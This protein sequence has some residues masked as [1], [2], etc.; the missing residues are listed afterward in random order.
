VKSCLKHTQKRRGDGKGG[1]EKRKEKRKLLFHPSMEKGNPKR[2][3]PSGSLTI[4]RWVS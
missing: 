3:S 4:S 2:V 1:E